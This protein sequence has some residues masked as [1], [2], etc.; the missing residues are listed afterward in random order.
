MT[1][2]NQHL[3]GT[4][5]RWS[6]V[7]DAGV[8][9]FPTWQNNSIVKSQNIT[10]KLPSS[11]A[12]ATMYGSNMN[13]LKDFTNPG[14]QFSEPAGVIAGGLYN[15]SLDL[16]KNNIDIAFRNKQSRNIGNSNGDEN[17]PL[18]INGGD[19]IFSN[20]KTK[21]LEQ[22]YETRLKVNAIKVEH[23]KNYKLEICLTI[24]YHHQ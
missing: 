18:T 19:D 3:N 14:G 22:K 13:Q 21:E 1:L 7:G 11:M 23:K 15:N 6:S 17:E 4:K 10:A 2:T 20:L 5:R 24:Q 9:Y 8:F 12:M 16:N